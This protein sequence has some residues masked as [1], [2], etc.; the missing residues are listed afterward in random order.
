MSHLF[1]ETFKHEPH[2]SHFAHFTMLSGKFNG[3]MDFKIT[4]NSNVVLRANRIIIDWKCGKKEH[5]WTADGYR[6]LFSKWMNILVWTESILIWLN[7]HHYCTV[8]IEDWDGFF[9]FG[10]TCFDLM[11]NLLSFFL[12]HTHAIICFHNY[13][14]ISLGGYIY[15]FIYISDRF[16]SNS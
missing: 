11:W 7:F 9:V 10:F 1:I 5:V 15:I 6:F 2:H 13:P 16:N 8:I 14:I 12:Y 4:R 3:W